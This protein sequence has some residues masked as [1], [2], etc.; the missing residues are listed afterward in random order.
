LLAVS[1]FWTPIRRYLRVFGIAAIFATI[2]ALCV[3]LVMVKQRRAGFVEAF[4][5]E[6]LFW[7]GW[8]LLAPA[9][10][11]AARRVP[12][13]QAPRTRAVCLHFAFALLAGLLQGV[14][15]LGVYT[16]VGPPSYQQPEAGSAVGAVLLWVPFGLFFYGMIATVGVALDYHAKLREREQTAAQLKALL[17][18]S[19]LG[20]LRMQLQPHF[21]FNALN[22]VAMLVRQGDAH[23]SIRVLARLA[24]LMRQLLDDEAP[25]EVP[26]DVELEFV[27][28]YLEIERIRFG[29]RLH[30]CI[31]ADA[32]ARATPVP[33][34]LLQPLVE[35]AIRHGIARRA[36]AARI[37]VSAVRRDGA[38]YILV[39]DDGP[40][41][42]SGGSPADSQ[43]IGL[44]NTRTRLQYLYG[45][46]ASLEITNGESGGA[47]VN[48]VLPVRSAQANA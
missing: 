28:R 27:G 48:V 4:H 33:H 14:F 45:D 34:L 21:L 31:D 30:V 46:D 8:A 11:W 35:N 29:D 15:S 24:E 12:V 5:H 44:R 42:P 43:G 18:E 40:G 36:E 19:R 1:S 37:D 10:L 7:Y 13:D 22:T 23:T 2:P 3:V 38:L 47:E 39:R 6:G 20:A 9:I 41:I 32:A 16:L 25:Q 17:V 26:L